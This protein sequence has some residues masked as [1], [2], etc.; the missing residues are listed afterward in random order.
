[1]KQRLFSVKD[2]KVGEFL[3]V[4]QARTIAEAE[5]SFSDAVN[6]PDHQFGKHPSDFVLC[7]LG[8]VDLETGDIRGELLVLAT[9]EELKHGANESKRTQQPLAQV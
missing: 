9:A 7:Q 5:R 3:P 2:T 8:E 6:S 1:M 4:F